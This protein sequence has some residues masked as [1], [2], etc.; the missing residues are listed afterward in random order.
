VQTAVDNLQLQDKIAYRVAAKAMDIARNQGA[1][2][3]SLLESV[4]DMVE[5]QGQQIDSSIT[6]SASSI[7]QNFD[8]R[9]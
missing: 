9:V 8:V 6:P 5:I 7:G 3:L 4:T 1:A 2:I